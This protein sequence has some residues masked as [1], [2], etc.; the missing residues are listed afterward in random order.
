MTNSDIA[1]DKKQII[2]NFMEKLIPYFSLLPKNKDN[3]K[4]LILSNLLFSAMPR[5]YKSHQKMISTRV[6]CIMCQ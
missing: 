4:K 3:M 5:I 6:K 2:A 1:V